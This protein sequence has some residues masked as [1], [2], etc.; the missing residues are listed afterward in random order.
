MSARRTL[1]HSAGMLFPPVIVIS[2]HNMGGKKF[3]CENCPFSSTNN[4]QY[5]PLTLAYFQANYM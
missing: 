1:E 2:M 4:G 5:S 3:K